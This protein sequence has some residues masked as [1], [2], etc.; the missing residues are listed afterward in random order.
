M[1]EKELQEIYD[2][3]PRYMSELVTYC[4]TEE[5]ESV[6]IPCDVCV[7]PRRSIYRFTVGFFSDIYY[8]IKLLERLFLTGG[9][10][11]GGVTYHSTD[12][13]ADVIRGYMSDEELFEKEMTDSLTYR[14]IHNN[15]GKIY[16][17]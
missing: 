5:S 3:L 2:N 17:D 6:V 12:G 11:M 13:I 8:T 7:L 14:A 16:I 10:K 4:G 9:C 1:Q 15:N